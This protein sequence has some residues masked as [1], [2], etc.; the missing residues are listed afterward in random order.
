MKTVDISSKEVQ[1]LNYN[2]YSF[3]TKK[4]ENAEFKVKSGIEL[5]TNIKEHKKNLKKKLCTVEISIEEFIF[6]TVSDIEH[7]FRDFS[8]KIIYYTECTDEI[9][10]E[11]EK[12]YLFYYLLEDVKTMV[13]EYTNKDKVPPIKMNNFM[14]NFKKD[15]KISE[16]PILT[17][18][19]V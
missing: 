17:I 3:N 2:K 11:D 19:M 5:H 9:L 8:L 15:K 4:E 18:N 7:L 6:N 16:K 13:N 10:S 14:M 1:F 12:Y